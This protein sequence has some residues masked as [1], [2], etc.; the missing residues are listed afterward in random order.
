M[1]I[2]ILLSFLLFSFAL[3][4]ASA[5]HTKSKSERKITVA[6]TWYVTDVG[7]FQLIFAD[8]E[9]RIEN[10]RDLKAQTPLTKFLADPAYDPE[11]VVV[12]DEK[13]GEWRMAETLEESLS[14]N[15][16]SGNTTVI[17]KKLSEIVEY[18]RTGRN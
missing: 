13:F 4:P 1:K 2:L 18:K 12:K 6:P 3:L 5:Q 9:G 10:L 17:R 15:E 7:G 16:N 14:Q 11:I 8:R